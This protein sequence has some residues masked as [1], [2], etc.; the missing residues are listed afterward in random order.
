MVRNAETDGPLLFT[1]GHSTRSLDELVN[2]LRSQEIT[3]LVDVRRYPGSRRHPQFA[4]ATLSEALGVA[5]IHYRHEEALG[6]RRS[7]RMHSPNGAWRNA[8]FRGYADYAN[9]A[10]FQV[11]LERV[12][13]GAKHVPTAIM[14][15]EAVPWRCHRRI[16]ADHA[17][18]RGWHVVHV[19]ETESRL[20]HEVHP[21]ARRRKAD[22]CVIYP[23]DQ[24]AQQDLWG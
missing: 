15:A 5:G 18:L 24:A 1:V 10:P 17:V 8:S 22:G 3:A 12:L 16:I 20:D 19:I 14:C 4:R 23:P 2:A 13:E 21:H 11:A 9:T 6:G 7:G